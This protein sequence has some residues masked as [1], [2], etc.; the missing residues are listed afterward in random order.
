MADPGDLAVS[1]A[2]WVFLLTGIV[3]WNPTE[4]LGV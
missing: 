3:G 4:I 1:G 2:V